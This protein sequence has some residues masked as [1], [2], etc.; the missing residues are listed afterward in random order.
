VLPHSNGISIS[1]NSPNSP[2]YSLD[3]GYESVYSEC[4][5]SE[6]NDMQA[7][8]AFRA[9]HSLQC[10]GI[11]ALR[12]VRIEHP[13]GGEY[14]TVEPVPCAKRIRRDTVAYTYGADSGRFYGAFCSA[15]CCEATQAHRAAMWHR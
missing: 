4:R 9:T 2:V 13:L 11:R 10:S 5:K 14:D 6:V 7:A 8:T 12:P 1:E 3:N 15:A